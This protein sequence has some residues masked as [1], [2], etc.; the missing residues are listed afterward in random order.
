MKL[1]E[2][3]YLQVLLTLWVLSIFLIANNEMPSYRQ[4][5]ASYFLGAMIAASARKAD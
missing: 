3:L 1:V 2:H 5:G 4:L